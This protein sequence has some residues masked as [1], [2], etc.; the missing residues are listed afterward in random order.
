VSLQP[1]PFSLIS[2]SLTLVG[3]VFGGFETENIF[4]VSPIGGPILFISFMS[5]AA[6]VLLNIFVAV[7]SE[8]YTE[9]QEDIKSWELFVDKIIFEDTM[10]ERTGTSDGNWLT[11]RTRKL[12]H[13][14]VTKLMAWTDDTPATQPMSEKDAVK[15]R[16]LS[17]RAAHNTISYTSDEIEELGWTPFIKE[18]KGLEDLIEMEQESNQST[19]QSLSGLAKEVDVLQKSLGKSEDTATGYR[20]SLDEKLLK[21]QR[22]I[23]R[24]EQKIEAGSGGSRTPLLSK[25]ASA[26]EM[27]RPP[28]AKGKSFDKVPPKLGKLL[29]K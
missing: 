6:L 7:I 2:S 14:L 13:F 25:K 16:V 15:N 8:Y 19:H 5:F 27:V 26:W 28:V 21:L 20:A 3:F 4:Q 10:E 9:T 23:E 11:R 22:H 18:K 12:S 29:L 1:G 17:N 24:M